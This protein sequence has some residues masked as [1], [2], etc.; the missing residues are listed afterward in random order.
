MKDRQKALAE[1]RGDIRYF[2]GK[3]PQPTTAARVAMREHRVAKAEENATNLASIARV[4][5]PVPS[6]MGDRAGG[7]E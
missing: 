5:G 2:W 6:A 3:L 7:D 1:A 4:C